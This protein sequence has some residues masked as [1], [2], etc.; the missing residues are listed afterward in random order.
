[1]IEAPAWLRRELPFDQ[2]DLNVRIVE[3]LST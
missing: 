1:V 3:V 2:T